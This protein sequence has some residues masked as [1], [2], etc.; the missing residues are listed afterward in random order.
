[1][2]SRDST[3]YYNAGSRCDK[4]GNCI[5]L[6]REDSNRLEI[7]RS[8]AEAVV[9]SFRRSTVS[10]PLASVVGEHLRTGRLAD[11]TQP[12]RRR[13]R[14]FAD[15]DIDAI[16]DHYHSYCHVCLSTGVVSVNALF[17]CCV[18][19]LNPFATALIK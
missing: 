12:A 15:S 1:M 19:C 2:Q 8:L 7:R 11:R 9:F 6:P 3:D 13:R 10:S 16:T 14:R 5:K 18:S 17:L 4:L